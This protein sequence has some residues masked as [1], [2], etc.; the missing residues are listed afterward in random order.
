MNALTDSDD[1]AIF[2]SYGKT[3]TTQEIRDDNDQYW[4]KKVK[5]GDVG[6]GWPYDNALSGP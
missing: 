3:A 6:E 4:D 5:S 2:V 1:A